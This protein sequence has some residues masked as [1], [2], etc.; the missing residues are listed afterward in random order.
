M[1][2]DSVR[3]DL[4]CPAEQAVLQASASHA[5]IAQLDRAS[6]YGGD[7]RWATGHRCGRSNPVKLTAGQ[8]QEIRLQRASGR[9]TD[10]IAAD[11]GVSSS[12]VSQIATGRL[13]ASAP[14]PLTRGHVPSDASIEDR[15]WPRVDRSAG[16]GG[17]WPWTALRDHDGYGRLSIGGTTVVASRAALELKL[18]RKIGAGIKA[19]HTC[20]WPPCV[21][22]DHL[23]E[24][25]SARGAARTTVSP[26]SPASQARVLP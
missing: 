23:F 9:L 2:G 5:A 8:A 25:S 14:G 18:R 1:P 15:L 13:W 6:V 3:A 21:N 16:P 26:S 7:V 22:P 4:S 19:C 10:D 11:F 17:C 12:L 24:G 20:D